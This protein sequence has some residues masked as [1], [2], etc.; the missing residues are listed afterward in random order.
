MACTC[1]V[2]GAF[3]REQ[4]QY[5]LLMIRLA[6]DHVTGGEAVISRLPRALEGRACDILPYAASTWPCTLNKA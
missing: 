6:D 2:S 3:W 4:M 1:E 5:W